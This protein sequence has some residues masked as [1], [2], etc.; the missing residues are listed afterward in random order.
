[1]PGEDILLRWMIIN[2]LTGINR[3]KV[4][5]RNRWGSCGWAELRRADMPDYDRIFSLQTTILFESTNRPQTSYAHAFAKNANLFRLGRA[6]A[7]I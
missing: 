5:F 6:S 2:M 1:M 7:A 3:S 4:F